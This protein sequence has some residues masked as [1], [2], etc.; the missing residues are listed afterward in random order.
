MKNT[1]ALLTMGACMTAAITAHAASESTKQQFQRVSDEYL[2]QVYFP[3]A[4]TIGTLSG[5]HQYDT[6]LEDYSRENI[7]AQ[8]AALHR[9]ETRVAAIPA[10]SLDETTRGDREVVLN[11]IRSTLLTLEIIRPWEKN[12]DIYSGG[13]SNA[14]FSLMERKF[15]SVDDRLRPV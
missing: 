12:P 11:N 9:Y 4:P 1:I 10:S 13:I 15:A 5:Y 2:D 6:Q 14:A 7:D 3:H 8:I